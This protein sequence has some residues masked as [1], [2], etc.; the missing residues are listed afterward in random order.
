MCLLKI[1]YDDIEDGIYAVKYIHNS[2]V[3]SHKVVHDNNIQHS[4]YYY[5]YILKH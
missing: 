2:V 3:F 5:K 4:T 1:A